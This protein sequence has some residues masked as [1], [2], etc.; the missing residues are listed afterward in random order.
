M[1]VGAAKISRCAGAP[2]CK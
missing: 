1:S 2:G